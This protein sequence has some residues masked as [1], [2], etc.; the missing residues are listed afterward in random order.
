MHVCIMYYV[1]LFVYVLRMCLRSGRDGYSPGSGGLR[2]MREVCCTEGNGERVSCASP[3][4]PSCSLCINSVRVQYTVCKTPRTLESAL[5]VFPRSANS[6]HTR[7]LH[8]S[9]IY[10][11]LLMR[12][13]QTKG[14]PQT[15]PKPQKRMKV[16]G[17]VGGMRECAR[18]SLARCPRNVCV[19]V[20]CA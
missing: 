20:F 15:T 3:P 11:D 9:N 7:A 14:W 16:S 8:S 2:S 19:C 5:L 6:D 10:C 4:P 18:R 12:Q 1:C 17:L 13:H